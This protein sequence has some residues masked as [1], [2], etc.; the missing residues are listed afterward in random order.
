MLAII[1]IQQIYDLINYMK[2]EVISYALPGNLLGNNIKKM[3]E[4]D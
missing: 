1:R 2:P 4:I 3:K